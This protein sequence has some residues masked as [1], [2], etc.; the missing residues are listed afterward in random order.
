MRIV[1]AP[2]K[3][4]G[5][6]S[7]PQAVEAMARGAREADPA[8]EIDLAPM[9]DGGEGTVEALVAATGGRFLTSRVS[10]PFGEPIDARWAMLGDGQTAAIEMAAASGLALVPIAGRDPSRT[11]T[12]GTGELLLAALRAGASRVILG[13]GGSATNDGGA[14]LA[15]ALGYR[16]LDAE[17]RDV[18]PVGGALDRVRRI[19][20]PDDMKLI[21]L[22]R[23][24]AACDVDNP[25]CGPRG[26]SAV[27]GPQKGADEEGVRRL[28][29]N[30]AHFAR[31][32][33]RD[34]GVEVADRAGSGAAGGLGAGLVAFAGAALG[35]GVELIVRTVG[36]ADRLRGADLCLTGEGA[37]D[38]SSAFGKTTVGV[39]REA[40]VS[41]VSDAGDRGRCR[42]WGRG[43]ARSGDRRLL[44]PV[45]T[46]D[47]PRNG[48]PR[49]PTAARLGHC[50]RGSGV[51]SRP[52]LA[53]MS[54]LGEFGLIRQIRDAVRADPRVPLGIGDDCA[55]VRFRA[56]SD[57]LVT[58][59]MLMDGRHFV[60]SECGPEAAGRKALGVNLSDI[61]A[62]AGVPVAA[63]V[64]I[65]L[66]RDNSVAV[67]RGLLDGLLPLAAEFGV[68]LAGGDT[69]RWDGPLVISVTLLGETTSH[70]PAR[71]DG[72][73]VGDAILVT[74][75]LGGSLLGRHLD[76]KPRVREALAIADLAPIGGMIDISD[77]FAADLGHLLDE[78]GG[79]GARIE[80]VPI[81]PDARAM[82]L[83][84]GRSALDHALHDGED[85]E[86]CL[87]LREP[88]AS[89]LLAHPP[90]P[91]H[92]VGTV[93]AEPGLIL[94]GPDGPSRLAPRGFDHLA[95]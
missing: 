65:A 70:G 76:P 56:G 93:V 17:G 49:R 51:P 81:H 28:D 30:L 41:G 27:Y 53:T 80:S 8:A 35:R 60:L 45:H 36:L 22:A 67:A 47:A 13:I 77:G 6:L 85:F 26:A 62:M 1:I 52:G 58:T 23:I 4:R 87:A 63:F 50:E 92:R 31:V 69:N 64:A 29:A 18:P 38:R 2:D 89:R 39:A 34:L 82:A 12:V 83:R 57:V 7:A 10:G 73:R 15:T 3:F 68:V 43:R 86:L 55:M 9:A 48:P 90:C 74:G 72:A 95:P 25:L 24:S 19:V 84:D 78:S 44:Q 40:R 54:P 11:S 94:I 32:I 91:L 59:D 20:P 79:L 16:L 33:E 66:P 71:R 75:P 61:A 46:S 42:R 88:D 37:L 14:G 5:S 21:R